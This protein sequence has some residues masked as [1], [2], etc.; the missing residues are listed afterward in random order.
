MQ[1]EKVET[2]IRALTPFGEKKGPENSHGPIV[3]IKCAVVLLF[4]LR[5]FV[6]AHE[7]FISPM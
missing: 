4:Q 3:G 7:S 2:T 1:G 6:C 5:A